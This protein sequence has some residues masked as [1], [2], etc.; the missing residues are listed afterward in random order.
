MRSW[1][2]IWGVNN[3]LALCKLNL[4]F[5]ILGEI[6]VWSYG[7]FNLLLAMCRLNL[8]FKILLEILVHHMGEVNHLLAMYRLNLNF[9]I[10]GEILWSVIWG[11]QSS[12]GHVQAK[13]ELQNFR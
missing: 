8:N 6:M 9:K 4:N 2:V 5:K 1:S 11:G 3:L 10:L 13:S 7:R 12:F